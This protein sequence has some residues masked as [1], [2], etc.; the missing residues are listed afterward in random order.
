M[1]TKKRPQASAD[2]PAVPRVV[3]NETQA[4]DHAVE[5]GRKRPFVAINDDG[6]LV[7]CSRRT[8]AKYGWESQGALYSR[9]GNN[10]A[11]ANKSSSKQTKVAP[12]K[13]QACQAKRAQP[14]RVALRAQLGE[15]CVPSLP[16]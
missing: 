5:S 4:M 6:K 10:A 13:R 8:A 1:A 7:V 3:R 2:R 15:R 12:W 9:N 16:H 14:P 11:P